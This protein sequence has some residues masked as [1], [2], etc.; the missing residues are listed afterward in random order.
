MPP[1]HLAPILR[2]GRARGGGRGK[3][4]VAAEITISER[5]AEIGDR[6]VP[7]RWEGDLVPG[8]NASAVGTLVERAMTLPP[9]WR[10]LR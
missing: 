5:P 4:F 2:R 6:A 10:T 9:L 3:S 1:S 7:G 8:L